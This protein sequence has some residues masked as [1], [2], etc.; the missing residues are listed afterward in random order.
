MDHGGANLSSPG[1]AKGDAASDCDRCPVRKTSFCHEVDISVPVLGRRRI[2]LKDGETISFACGGAPTLLNVISGFV[3]LVRA[4]PDGRTQILG[5]REMGD[6]LL[7]GTARQQTVTVEA[8][9]PVQACRFSWSRLK[10]QLQMHPQALALLL[11]KSQEQLE[12]MQSHLFDLG[13][14]NARERVASFLMRYGI[15]RDGSQGRRNLDAHLLLTRGE[16]ADFLGLTTETVS[17]TLAQMVK[18]GLVAL[19]RAQNIYVLDRDRL[20]FLA[21]D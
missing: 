7:L 9:G 6:F 16:I 13:R 12:G 11:S 18:E 2:R 8:V 21:N 19:G 20:R 14:K 10:G 17:R 3:K 4:L 15:A 5:F 1:L